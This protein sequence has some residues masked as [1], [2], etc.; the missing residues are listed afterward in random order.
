MAGSEGPGYALGL[1]DEVGDVDWAAKYQELFVR[2]GEQADRYQATI[3]RQKGIIDRMLKE[4]QVLEEENSR[5]KR[6]QRKTTS[7]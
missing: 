4:R 6:L 1:K 7:W 3:D 5:L 2:A